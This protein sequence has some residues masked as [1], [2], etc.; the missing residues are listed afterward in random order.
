MLIKDS[1][2]NYFHVNCSA[3]IVHYFHFGLPLKYYLVTPEGQCSTAV[4]GPDILAG[5]K[6]Q[7]IVPA[8][9]WKA[10]ELMETGESMGSSSPDYGLIS[11][12]VS[13]EFRYEDWKV[14]CEEDVKSLVAPENWNSI[15]HLIK[16]L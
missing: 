2:F 13:P 14:A 6:P 7:L 8:G 15:K 4:L 11:E 10:A 9:Y 12:A 5:Q 3:D 16:P 1:P